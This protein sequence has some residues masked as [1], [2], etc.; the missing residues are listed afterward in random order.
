MWVE[1][2]KGPSTFWPDHPQVWTIDFDQDRIFLDRNDVH[3][4][5]YFRLP[6][7]LTE[8]CTEDFVPYKPIDL[9]LWTPKQLS[10]SWTPICPDVVPLQLFDLVYRLVSDYHNSWRTY[11]YS[12]NS[13]SGLQKLGFGILS[14]FT[15]N[16]RARIDREH[17]TQYR[18]AP[19]N[20]LRW[21]TWP[22]PPIIPTILLGDTIIILS[23]DLQN[24]ARL[25][26]DHYMQVDC[27]HP[28]EADKT[29]VVTSLHAIQ[30]FMKSETKFV[31]THILPFL[32]EHGPPSQHAVVSL[33]NAIHGPWYPLATRI[34]KL[35]VELHDLILSYVTDC[36]IDRAVYAALLGIGVPFSWTVTCGKEKL[37]LRLVGKNNSRFHELLRPQRWLVF[38][39]D[40][41]GLMYQSP[42]I[43]KP[44][45]NQ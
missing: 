6:Y 24:A 37:P 5:H 42:E 16:F 8:L 19:S 20:L 28:T 43:E 12:I 34:H 45:G 41:L 23:L 7:G 14:C 3:L 4:V 2:L 38:F 30:I 39:D 18:S 26:Q 21:R 9:P 31:A 40:Y 27:N 36:D 44:V 15:L 32:P 22:T 1:P 10:L 29:Y 13:S 25:V 17:W 35:P 11:G 33:L